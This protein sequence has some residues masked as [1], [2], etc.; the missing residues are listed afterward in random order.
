MKWGRAQHGSKW[1]LSGNTNKE[2]TRAKGEPKKNVTGKARDRESSEQKSFVPQKSGS[3][4]GLSTI[5]DREWRHVN[6]LG[7]KTNH[8]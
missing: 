4:K 6:R 1:E 8:A 2:G 3:S 5:N 7:R